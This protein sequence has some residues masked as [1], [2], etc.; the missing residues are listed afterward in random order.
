MVL[1]IEALRTEEFPKV[2]QLPLNEL[3][4]VRFSTWALPSS[5]FISK[6]DSMPHHHGAEGNAAS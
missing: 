6:T 3:P 5:G 4:R 1:K 2:T